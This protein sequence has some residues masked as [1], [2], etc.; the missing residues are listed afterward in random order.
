MKTETSNKQDDA[1]NGSAVRDFPDSASSRRFSTEDFDAVWPHH[2]DYF[3]DVLNGDYALE[4]AIEDL[5][6]LIGSKWD[7]R[8]CSENTE[9][10]GGGSEPCEQE[11]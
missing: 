7:S 9:M 11:K 2:A 3:V 1:Q 4:E 10:R 6:G 5:R 8:V